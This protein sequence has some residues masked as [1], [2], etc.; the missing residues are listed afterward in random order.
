MIRGYHAYL[1]PEQLGFPL[2]AFVFIN[3]NKP[4]TGE[5][6]LEALARLELA[7]ELHRITGEDC[8]LLKVRARDTN[9]LRERLDRIGALESV[10]GVRTHLVLRSVEGTALQVAD[11]PDI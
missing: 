8:F 9:D 11:C 10:S 1:D 4:V 3:E 2:L 7:E 5:K 6:T